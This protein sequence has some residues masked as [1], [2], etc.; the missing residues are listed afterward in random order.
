MPRNKL[1]S[2]TGLPSKNT[3]RCHSCEAGAG[4]RGSEGR[5]NVCVLSLRQKQTLAL[6]SPL[7]I[8]LTKQKDTISQVEEG[9]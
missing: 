4:G 9:F 7:A 2:Y 8:L 1:I 5:V 3:K 6:S